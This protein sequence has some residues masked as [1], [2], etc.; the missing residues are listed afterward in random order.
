MQH[1]AV[2]LSF[3]KFTLHVL[4]C[5]PHPSSGIHKT[6]TTAS[7]TGHIFC[8]AASLQRGQ[9]WPRWREVAAVPEA[10]V[11]VLC[12]PD[13][14]RGWHPKHVQWTCRII[15][16]LLCVASRWTI[17]NINIKKFAFSLQW[18]ELEWNLFT[19]INSKMAAQFEVNW[20]VCRDLL[21]RRDFC[22][23]RVIYLSRLAFIYICVLILLKLGD[24][25]LGCRNIL[26]EKT[27]GLVIVA[28]LV[29]VEGVLSC[30]FSILYEWFANCGP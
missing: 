22:N 19:K 25:R 24:L 3:C 9:A 28:T 26:S 4:G 17:I 8:A 14:G 10:L 20:A 27:Q 15:N 18:H 30:L 11:T 13:D 5:Q 2:H 12:T 23:V 6:V 1:K 29:K 21:M 16:R 7:S